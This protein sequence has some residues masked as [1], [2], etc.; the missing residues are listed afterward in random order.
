MGRRDS[1]I[2]ELRACLAATRSS[3][4][5]RGPKLRDHR[6]S[7]TQSRSQSRMVSLLLIVTELDLSM[8]SERP[9]SGCST[10]IRN[11]L[12]WVSLFR[13]GHRRFG[14][15][16]LSS[17]ARSYNH[18]ASRYVKKSPN[19][20]SDRASNQRLRQCE[21]CFVAPR[22]V[23]ASARVNQCRQEKEG[24]SSYHHTQCGDLQECS[25]SNRLTDITQYNRLRSPEPKNAQRQKTATVSRSSVFL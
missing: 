9:Y 24:A 3:K 8:S 4:I 18:P 11:G 20:D 6:A 23:L 25:N 16:I 15:R 12:R 10:Y 17:H 2:F 19:L 7:G 21:D 1:R 13:Q 22:D 14:G 5:I